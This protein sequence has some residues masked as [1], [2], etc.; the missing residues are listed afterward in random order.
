MSHSEATVVE[1]CSGMMQFFLRKQFGKK[2]PSLMFD[3]VL[4]TSRLMVTNK[5]ILFYITLFYLCSM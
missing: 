4:N 2:A 3:R 5:L 1:P